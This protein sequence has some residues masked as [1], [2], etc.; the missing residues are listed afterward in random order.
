MIDI[1]EAKHGFRKALVFDKNLILPIEDLLHKGKCYLKGKISIDTITNIETERKINE[2]L[3]FSMLLHDVKYYDELSS[4][5]II[6][7]HEESLKNIKFSSPI[8]RTGFDVFTSDFYKSDNFR[9]LDMKLFLPGQEYLE[10]AIDEFYQETKIKHI[11]YNNILPKDKI[12]NMYF[13]IPHF[14]YSKFGKGDIYK[15]KNGN[16]YWIDMNNYTARKIK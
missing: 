14:E 10:I 16:V 8:P 5:A 3:N 4:Q 11:A 6:F 12:P 2:T 15:N 9:I 7:D 13:L 1:I